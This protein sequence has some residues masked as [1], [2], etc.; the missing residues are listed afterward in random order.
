[1]DENVSLCILV[2]RWENSIPFREILRKIRLVFGK[3][4]LA[5]FSSANNNGGSWGFGLVCTNVADD[6]FEMDLLFPTCELS[7]LITSWRY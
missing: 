1:M 6:V 7:V 4:V 5:G 2:I 3:A